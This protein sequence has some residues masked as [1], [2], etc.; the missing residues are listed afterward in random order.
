MLGGTQVKEESDILVDVLEDYTSGYV[1]IVHND[2]VNTFEW[3]IESL[4]KVCKHSFEQA[5]QSALI[6]HYSGKYSVKHGT[7]KELKPM[8]DALIDRGINATLESFD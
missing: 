7:K 1:L 5:E 3:V 2:E 8:K 4:V 6:I